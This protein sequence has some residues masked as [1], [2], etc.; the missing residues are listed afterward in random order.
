M[1]NQEEGVSRTADGRIAAIHE[2]QIANHAAELRADP[3]FRMAEPV[4]FRPNPESIKLSK[5]NEFIFAVDAEVFADKGTGIV[6]WPYHDFL[7]AAHPRT[8]IGQRAV[9]EKDQ[10]YRQFLPYTM[11]TQLKDGKTH[12]A[13]YHRTKLVGEE[14]LAGKVSIGWGGHPDIADLVTGSFVEESITNPGSLSAPVSPVINLYETL[15][16]SN[17]REIVE[18]LRLRDENGNVVDE[19][20]G[21]MA[22]SL[23]ILDT[24]AVGLVH[25]G[26]VRHAFISSTYT[27]ECREPE[28]L[29]IGFRSAEELLSGDYDLEGWTRLYL[30]YFVRS[31][32]L[33]RVA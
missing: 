10:R 3:T 8:I 31:G 7:A 14:K 25:V 17:N 6:E 1:S 27:V 32:E 33:T 11:V 29:Y 24:D 13:T 19:E 2:D 21:T 15:H 12:F 4:S 16:R 28:L 26:L 20:L 30:E 9:L 23:L 5:H 22:S 18:E